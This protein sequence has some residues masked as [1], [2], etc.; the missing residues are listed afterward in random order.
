MSKI[1]EFTENGRKYMKIEDVHF[2]KLSIRF[3]TKKPTEDKS[4]WEAECVLDRDTFRTIKKL[5]DK[6]SMSEIDTQE[7][8]HRLKFPAPYPE[9]DDQYVMRFRAS[10]EYKKRDGSG[11]E[12]VADDMALRPRMIL[13]HEDGTQEDMTLTRYANNGS[14]GDVILSMSVHPKFGTSLYL[15]RVEIPV[16]DFVEYVKPSN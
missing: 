7:F 4:F 15:K 14:R 9:K 8:E 11:M 2:G 5:T 3:F 13:I 12:K 1:V 6:I 10:T 16:K